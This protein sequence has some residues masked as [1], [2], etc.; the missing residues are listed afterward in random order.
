MSPVTDE[1]GQPPCEARHHLHPIQLFLH[2][3]DL[4]VGLRLFQPLKK[5]TEPLQPFFPVVV[6][7]PNFHGERVQL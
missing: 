6:L 1:L 5:P 2:L 3:F 4:T 7:L